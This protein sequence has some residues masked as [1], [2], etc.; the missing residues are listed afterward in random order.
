MSHITAP[1]PTVDAEIPRPRQHRARS[2]V[3]R[4]SSSS[5]LS[6]HRP[7]GMRTIWECP[8]SLIR[9]LDLAVLN[10]LLWAVVAA[11]WFTTTPMPHLPA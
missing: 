3:A 11:W 9:A 6:L 10:L 5:H 2:A 4:S 7:M 1:Y 8:A